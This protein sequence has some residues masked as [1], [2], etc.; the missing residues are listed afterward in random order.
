MRTGA[1]ATK[2]L[3]LA[4][5]IWEWISNQPGEKEGGGPDRAAFR[6]QPA[7]PAPSPAS[8]SNTPL[9][10]PVARHEKATQDSDRNGLVVNRF[11]L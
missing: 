9:T 5:N 4:A 11:N 10:Y 3:L 8:N 6:E 1:R 7:K 2:S